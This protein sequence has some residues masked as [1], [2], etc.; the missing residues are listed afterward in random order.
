M[1]IADQLSK[2][3][4]SSGCVSEELTVRRSRQLCYTDLPIKCARSSAGESNGF[5][6]QER[7]FALVF[8]SLRSVADARYFNYV[9]FAMRCVELRSF[10]AKIHATVENHREK[11]RTS[12]EVHARKDHR[13][14][15]RSIQ[16]A[17]KTPS[18]NAIRAG[19]A[20]E[21]I[22]GHHLVLPSHFGKQDRRQ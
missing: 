3:G 9:A 20:I 21:S 5:V 16:K 1:A 12:Y 8:T 10:A 17:S 18:S 7:L 14:L 22:F 2:I 19:S 4:W 13:A 11:W 6:I 15:K